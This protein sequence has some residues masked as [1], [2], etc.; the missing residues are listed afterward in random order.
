[1]D[2]YASLP[3]PTDTAMADNAAPD[4]DSM[5]PEQSV[6]HAPVDELE[7]PAKTHLGPAR[8]SPH[9][10]K[11]DGESVTESLDLRFQAPSPF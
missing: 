11:T 3:T 9:C 5:R 10:G 8:Q 2:I 1:M 7:M 4:V 6:L